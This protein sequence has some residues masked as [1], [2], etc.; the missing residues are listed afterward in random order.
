MA[1]GSVQ[2][3]YGYRVLHNRVLGPGKGG[4]RYHPDVTVQEVT[5]LTALMTWKCVLVKVPFGGAKGGV[6][7]DLKQ[8][9]EVEL[10]LPSQACQYPRPQD[11]IDGNQ[12]ST[13]RVPLETTPRASCG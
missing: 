7:C 13:P 2:T 4:I 11:I 1:D 9:D 8:L 3:F 5:A 10:S 6:L 12:S